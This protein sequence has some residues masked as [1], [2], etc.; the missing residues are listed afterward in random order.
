MEPMAP[1]AQ[2]LSNLASELG[3]F[4]FDTLHQTRSQGLLVYTPDTLREANTAMEHG[5]FED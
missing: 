5:P 4:M 3:K 2:K 1:P